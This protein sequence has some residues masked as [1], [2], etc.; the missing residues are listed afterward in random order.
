MFL[1]ITYLT[2]H[3]QIL[4][5]S[6]QF[7]F[8]RNTVSGTGAWSQMLEPVGCIIS[9]MVSISSDN[10]FAPNQWHVIIQGN[11]NL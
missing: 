4:H 5:T 6:Q 10:G 11:S 9:G 3:N 7:E 1:F 8:E 2:D